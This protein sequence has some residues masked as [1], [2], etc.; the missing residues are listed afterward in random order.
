MMKKNPLLIYAMAVLLLAGCASNELS[1]VR[2]ATF[3]IRYDNPGDSLNAWQYRKDS[4]CK[5]IHE[6]QFDVFG[7]QEVLHNQLQ[8]LLACLPEYAYVGVGRDDGKTQGEYAPVFYR[9]DKYDL[10]DSNTF[11][12]SEDP[13]AV[14]KLG[15]DAVC[16]RIATWAK[17][18]DKTTGKEFLMVNTHFDHIGTEARRHSALLIIDKIKE[19]AGTN[20][21]MMTG[22]FNVSEE[23]EAYKT[24]TSNE[25]VLKD[26]WKIAGK[27]SGESYT[28]HDFGRQPMAEREKIDF[29]FVTPQVT[30]KDAEVVSGALSD[31]LYLSDHNPHFA[32][33]EF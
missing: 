13:T 24:I 23:W 15:W 6:K 4:V 30:V 7:M 29:I 16:T 3:N 11:W 28:F 2:L 19:I 14:G 12:L 18:K 5:F 17:L 8:D 10:L 27:T 25:F 31:F 26:A 1:H 32:D 33:I 9:T 21:A 20:P 22:D